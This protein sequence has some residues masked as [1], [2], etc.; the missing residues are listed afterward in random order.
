MRDAA[1]S[2]PR[3]A[4]LPV[5]LAGLTA[6]AA[7]AAA[8]APA[9]EGPVTLRA[10]RPASTGVD[11]LRVKVRYAAG[12]V[13]VGAAPEGQ[14][15]RYRLTYDDD[16]FRPL[17]RWSLE[18]ELGDLTVGIRQ[19]A[20]RED[21]E[22][23]WWRRLLSLDFGF[24]FGDLDHEEGSLSLELAPDVPTRLD[25]EVGAAEGRL[26]LGGLSLREVSIR[27]GATD[28]EVTFQERNRVEMDRLAI[29]AGAAA[30][31]ASGLGNA[32]AREISVRGGV[33]DVKLDFTG[34]WSRNAEASVE[35]ALGSLR[36]VFPRG[37]GVRIRREGFLTSVEAP[38]FLNTE[39]GGL[40]TTNWASAD[41]RL[42]LTIRSALGSV[43]IDRVH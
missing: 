30:F 3:A 6:V 26:D 23:S 15:Y 4:A 33:G 24:G 5:L 13:D 21:S 28:T 34:A 20:D 18:E 16:V 7:V 43:E 39:G 35:M 22:R 10:S 14:L 2:R 37:L 9:Q 27:T 11:S 29:E 19:A 25:L 31:R 41:H 1:V 17:N 32:R 42:E 40:E 12:R 38:G 36:L 8:P